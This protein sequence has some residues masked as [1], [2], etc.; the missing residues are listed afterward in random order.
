MNA[1]TL[2]IWIALAAISTV[3]CLF[4]N[5]AV[6]QNF[7]MSGDDPQT[8][9]AQDA[10]TALAQNRRVTLTN[11]MV[12]IAHS[13]S[14]WVAVYDASGRALMSSGQL[15]GNP[16][17]LPD[18]V[19]AAVRSRGENRITWQPERGIRVATIV[20]FVAAPHARYVVSGRS[21]REIETR[22]E[23]LNRITIAS[24]IAILLLSLILARQLTPGRKK[25]S[26]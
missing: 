6:Q 24:W 5:L 13:L 20:E 12:D 19:F 23:N 14:P 1:A 15:D 8:Q 16:P 25:G 22:V 17:S 18:G 3:L 10:A 7:R 26:A 9:L 2:R 11:A 4:V 21:L